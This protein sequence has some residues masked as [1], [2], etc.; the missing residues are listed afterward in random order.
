MEYNPTI[1]EVLDFLEI[2]DIKYDIYTHPSLF[3]IEEAL[4]YW[5][6]IDATHVDGSG[7]LHCKNLFMRNHKGNRHYLI[8][9][10]C[11]KNLDIHSLEHM[12]HQGKLSFASPE[13]MERCL[14]VKPGSV[15]LFGLIHDINLENADPKEL[16]ENG[17]RV[18]FFYDAD[19]LKSDYVSFHPCDNTA[20]VVISRDDFLK[21][22]SLWGGESEALEI[23]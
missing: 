6:K 12:L 5:N 21:F 13:R 9:Y 20:T 22:L 11:H 3:T 2:N 1:Q 23:E 15:C 8:S 7:P 18:K 14:G 16:F 4:E 19:I 10:D 17:H